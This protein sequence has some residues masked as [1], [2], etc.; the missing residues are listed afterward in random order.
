MQSESEQGM[1][2]IV[3]FF[4]N[5]LNGVLGGLSAPIQPL[6]N[7]IGNTP[8]G[9][10]TA[11]PVIDASW[12]AMTLVADVA[13]G[14]IVTVAAIQVMY[15]QATGT[16]YMPVGQFV[17][18]AILTGI[19]IHA[20]GI[21]LQ[22]VLILNNE[23]CGALHLQVQQFIMQVNG[24]HP[25]DGGQALSLTTVLA[26]VFGVSLVRVV[27]QAVKRVVFFDLLYV[28]AG[29][30]FLMSFHPGTS[31]WFAYWLRTILTTA[32]SQFLQFLALSLGIQF[33]LASKQTGPTGFLLATAMLNLTAEIPELLARFAASAGASV[34]GAGSLLRSAITAAALFA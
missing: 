20:S 27:F 6:I 33:L 5:L 7:L 13:L 10:S 19:L 28:L 16:L 26:I 2:P 23:L 32:F 25:F 1:N 15:G 4:V 31:A 11:N 29:P 8:L 14:L 12:L 22:D 18:R 21:L 30:A 34:S 17:S 3:Q 9:V 24:G